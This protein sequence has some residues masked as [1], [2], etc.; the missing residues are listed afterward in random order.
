MHV[1][2]P[3]PFCFTNMNQT[4]CR[5]PIT[6][7][8]NRFRLT[9]ANDAT[10]VVQDQIL[11]FKKSDVVYNTP[12]FTTPTNIMTLKFAPL[13]SITGILLEKYIALLSKFISS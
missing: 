11:C 5:L 4:K 6:E 1:H 2:L 13:R 8:S 12:P 7:T 3:L 9:L 10:K